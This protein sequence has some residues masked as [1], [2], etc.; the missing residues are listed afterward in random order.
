MS[1]NKSYFTDYYEYNGGRVMMENNVMCKILGIGNVNLKLHD[2]TM[3]EL[4]QVRYVPELKRN[5]I[6]LRMLDQMGCSV[7]IE[8]GE[9]MIVK[10]S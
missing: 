5:M 7:R 9:L 1:L 3:R 6:S 8:L 4:K 2:K 10:D